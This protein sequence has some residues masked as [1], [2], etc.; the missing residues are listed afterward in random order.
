MTGMLESQENNSEN[1][2]TENVNITPTNNEESE[3]IYSSRNDIVKRFKEM[4]LLPISEVIDDVEKL[5]QSYLDLLK[6]DQDVIRQDY[7]TKNDTLDDFV[8]PEDETDNEFKE[9]S[10]QFNLLLIH[11][12]EGQQTSRSANLDKKNAILDRM[13]EIVQDSENVEKYYNEFVEISKEFKEIK[14]VQSS[15]VSLLWKKYQLL[16]ENFY[17]LLKINRELRDY[18][19]KKNLEK[20]EQICIEA[21]KI[22]ESKDIISGFKHLQ[23][24][25]DEWR[26][27][28]PVSKKDREEI[29]KRFKDISTMI[30]KKHHDYFS[31]VK[32][33]ETENEAKKIE[34]CVEIESINY[35]NLVSQKEWEEKTKFIL[36]LQDKWKQLGFASKKVNNQLFD[37]FRQGCDIFFS[38]KAEFFTS[39]KDQF[40][41]NLEKKIALCEKVEKLKDSTDWKNTSDELIKIQKEWKTIGPVPRKFSDSL[42]KR[43]ISACDY[44]FDQKTKQFSSQK[45]KEYENLEKKRTI[46]SKLK[47]IFEA[48]TTPDDNKNIRTLM[49]EWSTIGFVPFKDKDD[50]YKEY[51]GVVDKLFKKLNMHGAKQNIESFANHIN[52]YTDKDKHSL[53]KDRD[54]LMRSFENI[55]NEIKNYENNIGFLSS[56]SKGGNALVKEMEKKIAKLKDDLDVIV[57]KID[58]IDEKIQGN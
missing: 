21:E 42:W 55:K 31:Q 5:K 46:I 56:S 12:N 37:R 19:F 22:L 10:E 8:L 52:K 28:G 9:I 29:W 40:N 39:L 27:T 1:V 38:K 35:E 2:N 45:E 6:Q 41:E 36:S 20:K 34:I 50:V 25:H 26:N 4:L 16:M 24:L 57:N 54:R 32:E 47:D 7:L 33:K 43:F 15:E 51:Q 18:D 48:E 17:D 58:L 14:N 11:Y 53:Y 44:F 49:S 3:M 23:E 13:T 30:N